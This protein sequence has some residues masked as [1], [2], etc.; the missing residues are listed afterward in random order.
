[1]CNMNTHIVIEKIRDYQRLPYET[2]RNTSTSIFLNNKLF[3]YS[4]HL[5]LTVK[6]L[7]YQ[8]QTE[9]NTDVSSAT[10]TCGYGDLQNRLDQEIC[11]WHH[12]VVPG[13][14]QRYVTFIVTLNCLHKWHSIK[15]IATP[16][17][18]SSSV[19]GSNHTWI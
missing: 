8:T 1:M 16:L 11:S 15:A 10:K 9:V 5:F 19:V 13:L 2:C 18:T 3:M 4:F 17:S 7:R 14:C 6:I 12:Q